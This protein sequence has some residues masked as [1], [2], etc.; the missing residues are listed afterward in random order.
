MGTLS[1]GPERLWSIPAVGGEPRNLGLARNRLR[2]LRCH[3]DGRQLAFTAGEFKVELWAME[4]FLPDL[5][6][7]N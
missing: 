4:N 3:P 5:T 2:Y 1:E 6:A 7:A